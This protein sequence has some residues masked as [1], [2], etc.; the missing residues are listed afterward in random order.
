[1]R[2]NE[3]RTQSQRTFDDVAA[4]GP[5][6]AV[7][8]VVAE[9]ALTVEDLGCEETRL[10]VPS[11]LTHLKAWISDNDLRRRIINNILGP[12]IP[13]FPRSLAAAPLTA[14]GN[15][16]PGRGVIHLRIETRRVHIRQSIAKNLQSQARSIH[17][18]EAL[19]GGTKGRRS[20]RERDTEEGSG[21]TDL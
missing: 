2:V 7:S 9:T 15:R 19:R 3:S 14:I 4:A 10:S 8:G 11:S 18:Y 16:N 21:K 12:E 20:A 6:V 17:L 5:S 1:M 13:F